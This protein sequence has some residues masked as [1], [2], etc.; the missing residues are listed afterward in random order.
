MATSPVSDTGVTTRWWQGLVLVLLATVSLSLQNILAKIAQSPKAI[1]VLGGLAQLGGYVAPDPHNPFQ[2]PL[3]VLLVR[4]TFMVPLLWL[5]VLPLV[6][7]ETWAE[8]H[9]LIKGAN[10]SLKR[11]IVAAG[12]F[13][14]LSQTCIYIAIAKVGPA[15]AVTIFFIYPT[16][17][18]L[19]AWKLFRDRPSWLQWLAIG[20]IYAGCVLLTFSA[21]KAALQT[22]LW[23]ILA[24]IASGIIFALEGIVAQSCFDRLNP[25]TFTGFIFVV[26]WLALLAIALPFIHFELNGGLILMGFLLSLATLS[27]YLFNNFGIKAI[28]AAPTAII[29]SSGPAVTALLGVLLISDRLGPPQWIAI[30]IVTLGVGLMN[31]ARMHRSA[32]NGA[33]AE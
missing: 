31:L 7:R 2:V 5:L 12:L 11:R 26:E 18:T 1:P 24:A 25:A 15:T 8:A 10:I 6:R 29:G 21:P 19:L 27:G 3:L 30:F 32:L 13:L 20:L 22:D 28:G 33:D 16:V 9:Q 4:I 17:T 23:G 14:F